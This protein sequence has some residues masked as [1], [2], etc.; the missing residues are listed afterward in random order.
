MKTGLFGQQLTL[1]EELRAA[2]FLAHARLQTAPFFET[3]AA[4]QLPL[5][6]FIGQLRALA[7]V[8]AV[9][10]QAIEHC[11][12]ERVNSVWHV[13]MRRLP[14][15]HQDLRF[16]EPRAI[17]DLK[18]AA[19]AALVTADHVRLR[20]IESPL[21][22]LG[23]VYVLEGST[24][25]AVVLRPL[26]ARAFLLTDGEGLSYLG[27]DVPAVYARWQQ[28]QR[29]MNALRL[30]AG[31]R[32]QVVQAAGDFFVRIEE[33]YRALYPVNP[34]S[35]TLLATTINPEAGR[36]PVPS[37]AREAEAAL[38]AADDCWARFPYFEQRYG[39]RGRRFARSDAA[40][41][42]TLCR[43]D[44]AQIV[45]QVRWL[46]RLLA[47]RGMPTL[48]LQVQ[49]EILADSLTRAVPEEQ[50]RHGK[51]LLA[52]ADLRERRLGVLGENEVVAIAAEFDR[53]VGPE[54]SSRLPS[55]GHLLA[56][57]VADERSGSD[58]A[59]DNLRA[60]M[61]DASRFPTTWVAAVD[62]ALARARHAGST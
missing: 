62:A 59:V 60:W 3:L 53:A 47:A 24:L 32:E 43:L 21:A 5:E 57:A 33:I 28:Y 52:A 40:W 6:S 23:Y 18:E 49:L 9:I 55:T 41:L 27:S 10:E 13:D 61:T 2:T 7:V 38:E 1:M 35:R 22:L 46:G 48:L 12:D 56:A 29:R 30:D 58:N 4:C 54:W 34:G 36:H 51:L 42:A 25:G 44:P 20:S 15:L 19:T 31:E 14:S 39:D 45:S 16:L 50:A 37:D 11:P 26:Y 8:H 17:A